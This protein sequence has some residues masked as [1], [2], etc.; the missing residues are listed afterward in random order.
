MSFGLS[1]SDFLTVIQLS[2]K[3]RKQFVDAPDEFNALK[4]ELVFKIIV[5][6]DLLSSNPIPRIKGLSNVLRDLE[7]SEDLLLAQEL[8]D[9]QESR[10]QD[11]K[12]GCTK[13]LQDL[14]KMAERY[15]ELDKVPGRS[16]N[17]IRRVWKRLKWEPEDVKQLR[18]RLTSN[19][20]LLNTIH[21]S[22]LRCDMMLNSI[23]IRL[24]TIP[25]NTSFRVK[26]GVNRLNK[27]QDDQKRQMLVDWLAPTDFSNQHTDFISR[28]QEG[29][30]EW[31]LSSREYLQWRA[32]AQRTL[33]CPGIPGAGK[34]MMSSIV[35]DDLWKHFDQHPKYAIAYAYCSY[36]RQHEQTLVNLI[37]TLSRQLLQERSDLPDTVQSLYQRH[38]HKKTRPSVDELRVLLHSVTEIYSKVFIVV[39]AL[40]ECTEVDRTRDLLLS[41]LIHL[42]NQSKTVVCLLATTRFITEILDQFENCVKLEIRATEHD[43][44]RYLDS[45]ILRL[46]PC[47]ARRKDLQD[48]IKTKIIEAVDGM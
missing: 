32:G 9:E 25:R 23:L 20:A 41:E 14:N 31:L 16:D 45:Q 3:A 40:D 47:V 27:E 29:T 35:V 38:V 1:V 43:V 48:E 13:V 6:S 36:K 15:F 21:S 2:N 12:H 26:D 5:Y 28:R 39:D 8:S 18:A 46:A 33:L 34:T 4:H 42:Q 30:G 22:L 10:L 37:A 19:I 7:D 44:S 24:L 17:R 11:A